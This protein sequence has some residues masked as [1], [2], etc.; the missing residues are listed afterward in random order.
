[1]NGFINNPKI[2]FSNLDRLIDTYP[3]SVYEPILAELDDEVVRAYLYDASNRR[4]LFSKILDKLTPVL[5]RG[6][7]IILIAYFKDYTIG[8]AQRAWTAFLAMLDS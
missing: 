1:M 4:K 2:Y 3:P 6:A 8:L 5:K 7:S